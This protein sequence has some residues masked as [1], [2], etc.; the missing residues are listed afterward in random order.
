VVQGDR[1]AGLGPYPEL[2]AAFPAARVRGWDGLLTP[3]L[4]NRRGHWLLECAYH[5]DPREEIGVEPLHGPALTALGLDEAGWGASARRGLQRMLAHGT[6]AV[7]GPFERSSVRTAVARSGLSALSGLPAPSGPS[8]LPGDGSGGGLDPL[9]GCSLA[10]AAYGSL[11]VGGRADFAVFEQGP[12]GRPG[13]CLATVLAGR[14]L[15]R[16]R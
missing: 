13:A 4:L 12:S 15:Y 1:I 14:L 7:A 11:T 2:A 6:T 5:P 10:D 16:R 9:D 3:G 8:G